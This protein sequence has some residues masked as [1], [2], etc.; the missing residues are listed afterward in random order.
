MPTCTPTTAV[1]P[2][3]T[4]CLTV[5]ASIKISTRCFTRPKLLEKSPAELR[6]LW[7]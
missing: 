6:N 2:S 5:C 3:Y 4:Y 7:L 1:K